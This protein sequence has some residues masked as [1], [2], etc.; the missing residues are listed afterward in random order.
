MKKTAAT[1][2]AGK[3][4]RILNK[5][6]SCWQL[7]VFLI[8]AVLY[9]AV[10]RYA[11]M[12]GLTMAFSNYNPVAGLFKSP[13]VGFQHFIRFFQSPD[14]F[15]VIGNTLK[16]SILNL[17]FGFPIPIL[18]ALLINQTRNMRFKKVVQTTIYAPHFISMVIIVGML[19]LFLSP[20]SGII[21]KFLGLF[22]HEPV[23][24]MGNAAL[25]PA[26]YIIS[27]IWQ[28][29]GYN[30]I[31][32]IAALSGVSPELHE[33]A[34]VD[35][36]TVWQRIRYIDLPSIMPT[37]VVLLIMNS[38]RILTIGYEKI[39]LMQNSLNR[40]SSEVISTYVYRQAFGAVGLPNF[41]Y[42]TA[43]GLFESGVS[44]IMLLIVNHIA[45]KYSDTSLV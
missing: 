29:M 4:T 23:M 42:A 9:F 8:P 6:K 37:I 12:G 1:V 7:Y 45:S 31:V 27:E 39:F 32:Y 13:W 26:V 25:F 35:G 10:F 36:A 20:T 14:C 16:I 40:A 3:S 43:I 44:L 24:F 17:L 18:L 5:M 30:S 15:V 34:I 38:G 28:T 22:G 19:N 2:R 33:S 21:N 41:S 11:P